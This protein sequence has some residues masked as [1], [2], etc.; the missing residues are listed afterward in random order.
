MTQRQIHPSE[1]TQ[2]IQNRFTARFA[3]LGLLLL[4]LGLLGGASRSK[5]PESRMWLF[6]GALGSAV[7]CRIVHRIAI[8][9]ERLFSDARDIGLT[10]WQD[11]FFR[12]TRGESLTLEGEI[13][14]SD[15]E[16]ERMQLFDWN[17]LSDSDLHPVIAII[18]PMGGGKSRLVKFLGK[19][20]LFD[21]QPS[22]TAFDVYSRDG[23]WQRGV[24]EYDQ[25][26]EVMKTDLE[27]IDARKQQYRGGRNDFDPVLRVLE[28]GVDTLP[29]IKALSKDAGEVV[30]NWLR[31]HV[32]VARKVR[33]RLCLISVKLRGSDIGIGSESRDDSTVI[34][35][36]KKGIQKAMTDT[37]YFRLGA[38]QNA[39]LR[40]QLKASLAGIKHPALVYAGGEWFP[41]SIPQLNSAGDPVGM[42]SRDLLQTEQKSLP[43]SPDS[44]EDSEGDSPNQL[45]GIQGAILD[46]SERQGWIKAK[47][48][49][50]SG[51]GVFRDKSAGDIRAEF[52]ILIE[53]GFGVG[54]FEGERLQFCSH[55]WN[56]EDSE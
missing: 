38:K 55:D 37:R 15:R 42:P 4:S 29:N 28:E 40:E 3:A 18:S 43:E 31:A 11:Q 13:V 7:L 44:P 35:P 12:R 2:L 19:H 22:I 47:D 48:C 8:D 32:S 30:D 16:P 52:L 1:L 27:E 54:R 26:L 5:V 41:G 34:F 21:R 36:G 24:T 50:R 20:V 46:L 9:N 6:A 10:N 56:S 51:W 33:F 17:E 53:L 23:D 49:Q 25:M 45:S 39:E 14:Q